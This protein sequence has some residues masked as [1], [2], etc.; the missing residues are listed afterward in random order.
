MKVSELAKQA[1]VTADTV[2]HYTKIGL[3]QPQR[4][5]DN[6]YQRYD[7]DALKRLRFIQKAR[8]LGFSLQ[9]IGSI[10]HHRHSGASPCPMVRGLMAEHL[11]RVRKQI[12]EL[13]QQLTR[14]ERA[15]DAWEAMPDGEPDNAAICPLI[16]HWNNQ[17][18]RNHE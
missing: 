18:D 9:E 2:R 15:M 10:V 14:M 16:A 1:G 5:P 17:Q 6:G 4:D 11:P 12:A 3:L 8:L 13:Q 7:L